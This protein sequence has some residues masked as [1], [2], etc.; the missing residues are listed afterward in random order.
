M[1][2][3]HRVIWKNM[4][5][6]LD[7][8]FVIPSYRE[9]T[10]I[11]DLLSSIAVHG[12]IEWVKIWVFVV[13]NN[14]QDASQE[15][16]KSNEDTAWLIIDIIRE[17]NDLSRYS[18]VLQA[19][20]SDI[21]YFNMDIYLVDAYTEKWAI[22]NSNVWYARDIGTKSALN[23]LKNE[24]S[25]IVSTDA[26]CELNTWFTEELVKVFKPSQLNLWEKL[27][28]IATGHR[29]FVENK[30]EEHIFEKYK[31]ICDLESAI[32]SVVE[33]SIWIYE[34]KSRFGVAFTPWSHTIFTKE[35]FEEIGGYEHAKGAE[36]VWIWMSAMREWH[37]IEYYRWISI[38]TKSRVSSRT[39]DWHWFWNA[40][41]DKGD[42]S[43]LELHTLSVENIIAIET[44]KHQF[45][46]AHA[47]FQNNKIKWIEYIYGVL[48]TVIPLYERQSVEKIA[49]IY[50]KYIW[51]KNST[52]KSYPEDLFPSLLAEF[53]IELEKF[54]PKKSLLVVIQEIDDLINSIDEKSHFFK[55]I[56][57]MRD[58]WLNKEFLFTSD[59]H[60]W[61]YLDLMRLK[62]SCFHNI[63]ILEKFK[64]DYERSL[65]GFE[66]VLS[67]TSQTYPE[68]WEKCIDF[69]KNIMDVDTL[70]TSILELWETEGII[71]IFKGLYNHI[72]SN[73]FRPYWIKTKISLVFDIEDED[74]NGDN[75]IEELQIQINKF[76]IP[77]FLE[78]YDNLIIWINESCNMN[79]PLLKHLIN[80]DLLSSDSFDSE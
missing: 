55:E 7:I 9:W 36:D 22:N 1:L 8:A 19:Q 28:S 11:I 65:I 76:R 24:R 52:T 38:S 25:V 46:V 48:K 12:I 39:E 54:L 69:L 5:W 53:K 68:L 72:E 51:L 21:I 64:I 70:D 71:F 27:P 77:E 31:Y 78:N 16:V 49:D 29:L 58:M 59:S 73:I 15:D 26:D 50:F 61:L 56:I 62:L 20:I 60:I 67:N 33:K 47:Q 63:N 41:R 66:K 30:W 14:P 57:W 4:E 40:I 43:I 79:F 44:F 34:L 6:K 2:E 32:Y 13:V 80:L 17:K 23:F 18:D 42:T 35:L 10:E 74:A 45:S 3:N 75:L 37:D